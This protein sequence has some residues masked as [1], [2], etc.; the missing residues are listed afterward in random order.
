MR[1][2]QVKEERKH[3]L[4]ILRINSYRSKALHHPHA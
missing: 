1:D 4:P 3:G 2:G